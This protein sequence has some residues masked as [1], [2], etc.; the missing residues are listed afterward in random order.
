MRVSPKPFLPAFSRA[1][2]IRYNFP[3]VPTTRLFAILKTQDC[4]TASSW[5]LTTLQSR[6]VA[7]QFG[8][9]VINP[10]ARIRSRSR[11]GEKTLSSIKFSYPPTPMFLQ[12]NIYRLLDPLY[13]RV[14][15]RSEARSKDCTHSSFRRSVAKWPMRCCS[16]NPAL[17][18]S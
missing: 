15:P 3:F 6:S 5:S 10:V 9:R 2:Q 8:L 12:L 11:I 14:T 18:I 4:K 16:T 1:C 17:S 13:L 7:E